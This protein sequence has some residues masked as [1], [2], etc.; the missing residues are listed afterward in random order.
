MDEEILFDMFLES[1]ESD[2]RFDSFQESLKTVFE[3]GYQKGKAAIKEIK[4][5]QS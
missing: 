2:K 4:K 5:E 3:L 1:V